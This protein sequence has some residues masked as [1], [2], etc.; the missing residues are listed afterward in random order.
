[1]VSTC[2][3]G[4]ADIEHSTNWGRI[5]GYV[6]A[7]GDRCRCMAFE[8]ADAP[9]DPIPPPP[10][11]VPVFFPGPAERRRYA[12]LQAAAMIWRDSAIYQRSPAVVVSWAEALLA[13]I[14]RREQSKGEPK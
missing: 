1:M 2:K 11:M 7:D 10:P 6:S 14:E 4:H 8:C 3:C 9:S 5:C 13:E 12:L